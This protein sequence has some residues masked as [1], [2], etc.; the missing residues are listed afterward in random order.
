MADRLFQQNFVVS[1]QSAYVAKARKADI[2]RRLAKERRFP[3]T[4]RPFGGEILVNKNDM[5]SEW[6]PD[7]AGSHSGQISVRSASEIASSMS[8]PR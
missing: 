3:L 7:A 8:T 2:P 6:L 4:F 5:S 1:G